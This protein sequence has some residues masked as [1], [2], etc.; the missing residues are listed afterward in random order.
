MRPQVFT[1]T[2]PLQQGPFQKIKKKTLKTTLQTKGRKENITGGAGGHSLDFPNF[3]NL[4]KIVGLFFWCAIMLAYAW[5]GL[6]VIEVA[7]RGFELGEAELK[8]ELLQARR[9][10]ALAAEQQ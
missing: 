9:H 7:Q 3:C 5:F 10:H 6:G 8:A 1:K 2:R 4:A